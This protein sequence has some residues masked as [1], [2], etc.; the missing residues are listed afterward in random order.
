M[1][2][3]EAM[4]S[5]LLVPHGII[6]KMVGVNWEEV[7]MQREHSVPFLQV[8]AEQKGLWTPSA[9]CAPLLNALDFSNMCALEI[10]FGIRRL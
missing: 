6:V 5:S 4:R 2:L 9:F 8:G 3:R 10:F 7:Q 1:D